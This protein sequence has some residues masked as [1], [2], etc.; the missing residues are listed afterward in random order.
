MPARN[1][2]ANDLGIHVLSEAEFQKLIAQEYNLK[3]STFTLNEL[4]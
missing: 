3:Q 2:K 1:C 4:L